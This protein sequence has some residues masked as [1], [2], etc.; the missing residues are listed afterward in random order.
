MNPEK[1]LGMEDTYALLDRLGVGVVSFVDGDGFPYAVP[2]NYV[3]IGEKI[4]IHGSK[5]GTKADCIRSS[6]KC[7]LVAFDEKGFDDY[8]G[9]ACDT[10]T[11]YESVVVRGSVSEIEDTAKKTEVLR[12]ITDRL[13]PSKKDCPIAPER[14]A[15]TGIFE[16][17]IDAITGKYRS[18]K[19]NGKLLSV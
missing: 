10:S 9:N 16:I 15:F 7:C 12:A 11:V 4:Y 17:S 18:L 14:V 3:R 1:I 8:G 2:V 6:G 19:P 5:K 13:V